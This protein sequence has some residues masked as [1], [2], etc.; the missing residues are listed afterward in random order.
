MITRED[1]IKSVPVDAEIAGR[2]YDELM[3]SCDGINLE[4]AE[5]HLKNIIDGFRIGKLR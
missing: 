1:F 5:K 4:I 3:S 2:T